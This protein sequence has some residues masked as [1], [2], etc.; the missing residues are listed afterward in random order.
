MGSQISAE[1]QIYI[2]IGYVIFYAQWF[3]HKNWKLEI[4]KKIFLLYNPEKLVVYTAKKLREY[5]F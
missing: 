2:P 1:K 3:L 4:V 5:D